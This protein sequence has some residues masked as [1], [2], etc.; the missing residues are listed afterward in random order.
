MRLVNGGLD[1]LSVKDN[2]SGVPRSALAACTKRHYTSKIACFED[3]LG[4]TSYGFRGEA[5]NSLCAVAEKFSIVTKTAEDAHAVRVT[6]DVSGD[7]AS[8]VEM[9]DTVT[10]N[11]GGATQ[12]LA[13]D[14]GGDTGTEVVVAGLF[15]HLPVRRKVFLEKQRKEPFFKKVREVVTA[16]AL[17][18]PNV[19][20]AVVAQGKPAFL[21]RPVADVEAAIAG[22]FGQE[23]LSQLEHVTSQT[24]DH[25]DEVDAEEITSR[26]SQGGNGGDDERETGERPLASSLAKRG[27]PYASPAASPMAA[28]LRRHQSPSG[29][30]SPV[31]MVRRAAA[32]S[33]FTVDVEAWIP[34][35]SARSQQSVVSRT[36]ND[37]CFLFV[38]SRPCDMKKVTGEITKAFRRQLPSSS[39]RFPFMLVNIKVPYTDH[40]ASHAH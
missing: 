24:N 15:K 37:R 12:S 21:K 20:M 27:R 32:A 36:R 25:L 4:V 31:Q 1:M 11:D 28:V 13:G 38:N 10:A 5:L 23:L 8:Q 18:H 40:V 17:A 30:R 39:S 22:I 7:I 14:R 26:L 16:Y 33:D 19:K 6:Y 2:G 3:L 29:G 35:P 9:A 34:K